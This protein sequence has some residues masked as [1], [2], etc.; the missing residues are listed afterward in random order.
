MADP[1][2][3]IQAEPFGIGFAVLILPPPMGIGHDAEFPG[4]DEAL[5]YALRLQRTMRWRIRDLVEGEAR[6]ER[7]A[8][9]GEPT[10]ER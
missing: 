10:T 8:A 7:W 9:E 2:I 5:A 6:L 4:Y 3:S 1:V